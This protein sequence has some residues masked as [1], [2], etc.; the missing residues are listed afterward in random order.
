VNSVLTLLVRFFPAAFR[1]QFEA[2][3]VEQVQTDYGRA[4]SRGRFAAWGF[5]V[6]TAVNLAR[7]GLAERLRP[8]VTRE[9]EW[10]RP[11]GR[12]WTMENWMKDLRHA[13]R[14]LRHS[15]G[16]AVVSVVTLGLAIGANAGIFSVV[17]TVL[18]DPLPYANVDRLVY[19]AATAPGT[20]LPEEFGISTEFYLQYREEVDAIEDAAVY[21]S[22]TSTL[23]AADR[24]ERVRMSFPSPSLF[25]TLGATPILGRLPVAED[26][27][28]T[29][30]ISYNLWTTWFGNDSG[31]VGRSYYI[32]GRMRAVVGVMGPDFG[33]PREDVT[34]W[35]PFE[36]KAEDVV[37]GRFGGDL[38]ARVAPGVSRQVLVDQLTA[39]ARRLPERFG[40]TANYARVIERHRPVVRSLEEQLLGQVATPLWVLLGAVG[41]VLLIACANVAN[42]FIV[43][44]SRR[45][46]DLA[47]RRAM[48]ATR[49]EL[50]RSLML[51]TAVVAA[52]AGVLAVALA[53]VSVP[54]FLQAAPANVP[55]LGDVRIGIPT[56]LFTLGASVVAALL[57]G[58]IPA[59]QASAPDLNRLRDGSRG[60][61]HRRH[62]GRDALVVAQTSLALVL[63]IGSGLLIR[64]FSALRHVDPGYD[65]ADVFTFQ[66]APEGADL[67]DGPSYARFHMNFASRVAALPGVRSVGLVENVPLNEGVRTDRFQAEGRGTEADAGTLLGYTWTGGDYFSTMG[68]ALLHGRT[69]READM[70]SDHG[71][72]LISR[73]AAELV[74]PGEDPIGRRLHI[75][76]S[77]NWWTVVG[78]V[79]DV[80]QY[81]FRGTGDPLVYFPLVGPTPDSWTISSPGYV[82]K[83]SR[84]EEIAPEVRA[85]VREVA[86]TAPMYRVFTMKELAADTIVQ[87]SFTMLMLG[88]A[89][90]LALILGAIGL[91]GVLSYVV[92]E[93]T[94]EIGVR[95]ALG[96]EAVQVQR[97]VVGQGTRV[98][99][100]GLAIGVAVALASTRVLGNLLYTV[101]TADLV[102]FVG[103]SAAMLA[104]GLL[105]SYVPARRASRV[106]PVE[107]LRGE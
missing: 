61:T 28:Q 16:F 27:G 1:D 49:A 13:M 37:P 58:L 51:E 98:V 9:S 104:V 81:D 82:V 40:G 90:G 79:K 39:A 87:V 55:R 78:E 102:T 73:K 74:W 26:E 42:L 24:I 65:T 44:A 71:N 4:R 92:A 105:A 31:V 29:A 86:P 14:S 30:V 62:W 54:L 5:V 56:L 35:V 21:N 107:A 64:T 15:P 67:K 66:I 94:R 106:D 34:L 84:A 19:I 3:I 36:P 75:V 60:S 93:R 7:S 57:C 97:M 103:M 2:D 70:E 48:G 89:S 68:I 43:R 96:A 95:M 52:G 8:S 47:V 32:N 63:L 20:E 85:L 38:V 46:R 22:F 77:E 11:M 41:I 45:Q 25:S 88:V 33:F 12:R 53:Y 17:D 6:A 10:T 91:Y 99:L 76:G 69:F 101:G 18:L 23:R 83:T 80:M 72:V 100:L 50:M 59:A